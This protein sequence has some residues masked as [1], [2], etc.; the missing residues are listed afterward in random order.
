M[1]WQIPKI[2]KQYAGAMIDN[3]FENKILL[4]VNKRL[5]TEEDEKD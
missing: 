3:V 1:S 4:K 2:I 5:N